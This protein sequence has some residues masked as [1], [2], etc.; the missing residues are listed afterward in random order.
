[1]LIGMIEFKIELLFRAF[2]EATITTIFNSLLWIA[3]T[4]IKV[5]INF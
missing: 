2:V 1:M 5:L 4:F 3:I